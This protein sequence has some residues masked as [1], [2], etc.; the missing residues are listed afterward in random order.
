MQ[1]FPSTRLRPFARW[2]SESGEYARS[3]ASGDHQRV[4]AESLV[5][6][7]AALCLPSTDATP[8][9]IAAEIT[10]LFGDSARL[11]RMAQRATKLGRPEAAHA[12][13]LDL[14]GLARLRGS[15]SASGLADAARPLARTP[16]RAGSFEPPL[17][18]HPFGRHEAREGAN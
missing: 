17:N 12:I 13:A 2:G 14:L 7:G 18:L 6:A 15:R 8:A 11:T 9:R 10:A 4:N 5:R 1:R 3:F 16:P